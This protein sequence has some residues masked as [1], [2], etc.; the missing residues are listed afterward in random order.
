MLELAY[1]W[2]REGGNPFSMDSPAVMLHCVFSNLESRLLET[3]AHNLCGL[4]KSSAE[5]CEVADSPGD[6]LVLIAVHCASCSKGAGE[7][8]TCVLRTRALGYPFQ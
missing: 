6:F 5:V 8:S 4:N 3:I 7:I 1:G 2:P